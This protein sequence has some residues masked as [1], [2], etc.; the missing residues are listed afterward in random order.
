MKGQIAI[1]EILV[2]NNKL[3]WNVFD[4]FKNE[5]SQFATSAKAGWYAYILRDGVYYFL[6]SDGNEWATEKYLDLLKKEGYILAFPIHKQT[7][8]EVFS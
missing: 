4:F 3:G 7:I 6:W 2:K 1:P 5:L 8:S